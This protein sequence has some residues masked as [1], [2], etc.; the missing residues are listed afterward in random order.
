MDLAFDALIMLRLWGLMPD[1]NS[2]SC[3]MDIVCSQSDNIWRV[4]LLLSRIKEDGLVADSNM[5][6][7]FVSTPIPTLTWAGLEVIGSVYWTDICL[8]CCPLLKKQRSLPLNDVWLL[9]SFQVN[10]FMYTPVL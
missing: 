9:W 5:Y 1:P 3:M 8:L 4:T 7:K 10:Y 2:Y 6:W